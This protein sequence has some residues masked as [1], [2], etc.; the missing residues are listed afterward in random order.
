M[1]NLLVKN[2]NI[3]RRSKMSNIYLVDLENVHHPGIK[4][5]HI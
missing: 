2:K 3:K 5:L 4:M 1:Q